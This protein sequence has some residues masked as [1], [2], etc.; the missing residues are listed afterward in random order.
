[1]RELSTRSEVFELL[2][3]PLYSRRR[4][5]GG[6]ARNDADFTKEDI[7]KVAFL[8]LE[9]DPHC[10]SSIHR[11]EYATLVSHFL[12]ELTFIIAHALQG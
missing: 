8:R 10:L 1:M 4:L 5:N 9:L 2:P 3:S 7:D 6:L 12:R 11:Q